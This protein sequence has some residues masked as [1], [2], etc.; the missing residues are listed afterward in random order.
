M[1]LN[2]ISREVI[3]CCIEVHKNLG[4]GLL[5]SVYERA[6][7]IEFR[8]ASISFERQK[9]LAVKYKNEK[10]GKFIIDI[11]VENK[12]VLELKSV[13]THNKIYEAQLLNYLKL[14]NYKLGLLI[15]FNTHLLRDGIKRIIL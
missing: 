2:E 4:P 13:E 7:C 14:G 1:E 15:N 5:E 6:L 9:E 11:L 12:V 3:R 8:S 10:I